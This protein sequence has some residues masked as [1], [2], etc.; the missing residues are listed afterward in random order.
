M[1]KYKNIE[2]S[3]NEMSQ[4]AP[5]PN[6]FKILDHGTYYYPAWK[7]YDREVNVLCD[8]CGESNIRACIGLGERDLCL[9]C[10]HE[11]TKKKTTYELTK[12]ITTSMHDH[13]CMFNCYNN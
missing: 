6:Y 11:L 12:K 2:Y 10:M 3:H 8:R 5:S 1:D 7:H 9:M 13:D 4:C